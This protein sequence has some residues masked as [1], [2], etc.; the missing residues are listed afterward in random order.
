MANPRRDEEL[1]NRHLAGAPGAFDELVERYSGELYGFLARFVGNSSAADDLVQD[2]FLQVHLAAGSFD[3]SRS[4][5]P[6]LY[7]IAAN[8]ARDFLRSRMRHPVRSLDAPANRGDDDSAGAGE[9]IADDGAP[10]DQT[11]DAELQR[12]RVRSVVD[13]LP[14][15]LR[16]ILMLGYFQQLPYAEIAEVLDIPVGTV[17]SRLHA[18]VQHFARLWQQE[19]DSAAPPE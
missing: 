8:K 15:H 12:R 2:T 6:W 16:L 17:K 13:R 5:K 1:L 3:E 18:A 19:H 4:F 10:A 14:E 7:T 11:L 9:R